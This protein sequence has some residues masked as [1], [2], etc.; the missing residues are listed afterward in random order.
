MADVFTWPVGR[1]SPDGQITW[2]PQHARVPLA[3]LVGSV[4]GSAALAA[5]CI[6]VGETAGASNIA[7]QLVYWAVAALIAVA[8]LLQYRGGLAPLP[9]SK[10]QVPRAWLRWNRRWK[11]ALAY[12][13]VIGMGVFT[14]MGFAATYVL[15]GAM[16]VMGSVPLAIAV[17]V[18]YGATKGLIV[19]ASWVA[20]SVLSRSAPW[21]RF[22]ITRKRQLELCLSGISVV[23]LVAVVLA[24]PPA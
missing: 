21:E 24:P 16:V 19:L 12:G 5:V 3:Y 1:A 7:V 14:N 15:L 8:S 20:N 2:R 9:E 6:G 11:T 4:L 10:A 18:V 17:G 23:T 22:V 13:L